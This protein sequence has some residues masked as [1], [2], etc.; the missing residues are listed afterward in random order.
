M[1]PGR[2]LG[3]WCWCRS[4]I[5]VA[6]G[7]ASSA[8]GGAGMRVSRFEFFEGCDADSQHLGN[9]SSNIPYREKVKIG[10]VLE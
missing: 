2:Y 8:P 3:Y 9:C 7:L 10:R 5:W 6:Q 1:M 4:L